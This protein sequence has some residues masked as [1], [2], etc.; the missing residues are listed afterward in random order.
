MP[1]DDAIINPQKGKNTP[2]LGPVVIM[3]ATE[4][5]MGS[6][7]SQLQFNR[8]NC[9]KLFVSRLYMKSDNSK[10]I[11]LTGPAVGAPYAVMVLETLIA[12]GARRVLFVGWCGAIAD[13]LVVG[14]ILLPTSAIIDEGTSRHYNSGELISR[15][16]E[17]LVTTMRK[18]MQKNATVFR[19]GA[20]WTTDAVF[21]ETRE[22]V[23]AFRN[24][25]ALAVEMEMSALFTVARFRGVEMAGLLV[26]SDDLSELN[27][28]PG[29]KDNRFKSGRKTMCQLV[30]KLCLTL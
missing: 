28:E 3:A 15:P 30:S 26:V 5:D 20:I 4:T 29:F 1:N 27:W 7:C 17:S 8:E 13:D 12:W 16:S 18:T 23:A 22:K 19:E 6:L 24:R 14:N 2:D 9:R 25:G 11:A 21:R 10:D